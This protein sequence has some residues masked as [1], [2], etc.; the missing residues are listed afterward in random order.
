MPTDIRY[1]PSR[2]HSYVSANETSVMVD[3]SS[4]TT[5]A[6]ADI[7]VTTARLYHNGKTHMA[8]HHNFATTWYEGHRCRHFHCQQSET[9]DIMSGWTEYET[10]VRNEITERGALVR[11]K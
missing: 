5:F 4:R 11:F 10:G 9:G 6:G 3:G 8:C 1:K 2:I 7:P